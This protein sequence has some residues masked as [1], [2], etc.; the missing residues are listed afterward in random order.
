MDGVAKTIKS[1]LDTLLTQLELDQQMEV[2]EF[3]KKLV[4]K[5]E[6]NQMIQDSENDILMNRSKSFNQFNED[7][8]DWKAKRK[9]TLR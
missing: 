9:D 2:M 5:S 7:F 1:N 4:E 8:E 3:A 6:I